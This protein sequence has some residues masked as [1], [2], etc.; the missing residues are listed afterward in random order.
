MDAAILTQLI[1]DKYEFMRPITDGWIRMFE[2]AKESRSGFDAVARQCTEFFSGA[3]GFMWEKE[4][5]KKYMGGNM[6]PR[7][8]ITMA[9]AFELVAL[10][11]PVLYWKNPQR[12]VR[13]RKGINYSPEM[14]GGQQDPRSQQ[15]FQQAQMEQQM[16][17]A[18]DSARCQL[19]ESWLNYTPLEMPG[20]G[21][22]SH[23]EMAITQALVT[24]RG[25]LWPEPY[26]MPGSERVLTGCFFDSQDNLF[27]DPDATCL[28]DAMWIC[29]RRVEPYWVA[30]RKFKL[31]PGTLKQYATMESVSTQTDVKNSTFGRNDRAQGKTND[32]LIYMEFFSKMGVGARIRNVDTPLREAF[33]RVVGDYA[34]VA[35]SRDVPFPLNAP[36]KMILD[37]SDDDVEKAFRWPVPYW[38]D[39]RWPCA[40]LDF[41]RKWNEPYPIPPMAPGLGELAYLNVFMSHLA[42]R[43]WTSSRD[44][45]VVLEAAKKYIEPALKNGEDLSILSLPSNFKSIKD[46]VDFLQQPQVN[47]DAWEIIDRLTAQFEKRVG[48]NELLYGLNPGGTQSRTAT[49]TEAKKDFLS[50]RPDYMAG[51]VEAWQQ[52][53]ADLEKI[54]TRWFVK[55]E[56][57][58][59]KF[60]KIGAMLWG[61]HVSTSDP[62]SIV[63][64]MRAGVEAGSVRKPNKAREA[65]NMQTVLPILFPELSKH[66]DATGDTNPINALIKH[67]G[68]AIEE[69]VDDMMMGQRRPPP[70]DE[71]ANM[72]K[73]QM[74]LT[75]QKTGAEVQKITADA[76]LSQVEAVVKQTEIQTA[77]AEVEKAQLESEG[78][79]QKMMAAMQKMQM[80][81]QK[82]HAELQMKAEGF[83]QK[84]AADQQSGE[85]KIAQG[86]QKLELDKAAGVQKLELDRAMGEM[87]LEQER[88]KIELA[89]VDAALGL[90]Q[91][92]DDHAL[93]MGQDS[94]SHM[95]EMDSKQDAHEQ[96]VKQTQEM[97]K[98]KVDAAKKA[99]AA[100][101]KGN[102]K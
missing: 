93:Q 36:T 90:R 67:W 51:K 70:D 28:Q 101:P 17:A 2:S 43:I 44:F 73:E 87:K 77:G 46:V 10:Y 56:H 99:A 100:K 14:F 62:E 58:E 48:L 75:N 20:G 71:M 55:P 8:K 81:L 97:S 72:Q 78:E 53:A 102:S 79:R 6:S 91:K 80:D 4:Y 18:S 3:I 89:R 94:E 86:A 85:V 98:A 12:T 45:I 23:S 7:F 66:A 1:S 54:C 11:G 30:E 96:S 42:G 61:Q 35:V 33:D 52:D 76:Q 21:L 27:I 83:Q 49:D 39:N 88:Q 38:M 64:D 69:N 26:T 9:K 29:R 57:V 41:Y 74:Q 59:S 82:D 92:S 32:M 63:R 47:K 31:P 24:G 34:Y 37:G 84:L 16:M 13:T 5:A 68:E 19:L 15:M 25:V 60:G 22:A 65:Q 40:V 95:R 50:V